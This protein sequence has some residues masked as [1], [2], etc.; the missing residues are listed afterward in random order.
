[1]E[2]LGRELPSPRACRAG[3]SEAFAPALA[4]PRASTACGRRMPWWVRWTG[5]GEASSRVEAT[6]RASVTRWISRVSRF[7]SAQRPHTH[8]CCS[9]WRPSRTCSYVG[10]A[11]ARR[12][13]QALPEA[14]RERVDA[15]R[16]CQEPCLSEPGQHL[17]LQ[18][19]DATSL[20]FK[21]SEDVVVALRLLLD[22]RRH[23]L[24]WAALAA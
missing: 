3:A 15:L 16:A 11:L 13:E 8:G 10:D 22:L 7:S 20:A 4:H 5:R 21:P 2:V 6:V 17:R 12:P 1:M 23:R 24:S 9:T 18:L 14:A 19:L